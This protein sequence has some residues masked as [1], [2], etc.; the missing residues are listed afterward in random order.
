[1]FASWGSPGIRLD[2]WRALSL[3][4]GLVFDLAAQGDRL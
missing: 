4:T 2:L 3:P 1:M